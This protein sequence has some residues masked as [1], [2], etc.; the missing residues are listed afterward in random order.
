M[1][2]RLDHTRVCTYASS[3]DRHHLVRFTW[4]REIYFVIGLYAT[5]RLVALTPVTKVVRLA[6][7]VMQIL[8]YPIAK[9]LAD[10]LDRVAANRCVLQLAHVHH[11]HAVYSQIA[12]LSRRDHRTHRYV[13]DCQR[14]LRLPSVTRLEQMTY[15]TQLSID[16]LVANVE[17]LRLYS[18]GL[19]EFFLCKVHKQNANED[20]DDGVQR[21]DSKFDWIR[22]VE[23][24]TMVKY[25]HRSVSEEEF[26]IKILVRYSFSLRY[27]LSQQTLELIENNPRYTRVRSRIYIW[28]LESFLVVYWKL[29]ELSLS[30]WSFKVEKTVGGSHRISTLRVTNPLCRARRHLVSHR[31]AFFVID[32]WRQRG[33]CFISSCS[34]TRSLKYVI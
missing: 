24:E 4:D 32:R 31:G 30:R 28:R 18:P 6:L 3:V 14:T 11:V 34:S 27:T 20:P 25:E 26:S 8:Q 12:S 19:N 33:P 17:P 16:T 22:F 15:L 7:D 10:W 29:S 13:V 1:I 2:F 9:L 21:H 23:L 5:M